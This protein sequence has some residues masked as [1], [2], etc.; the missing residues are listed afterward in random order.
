V[1]FLFDVKHGLRCNA[2]LVARGHTTAEPKDNTYSNVASPFSMIVGMLLAELNTL[3]MC[4]G[5]VG[6]TYLEAYAEDKAV[7]IVGTEFGPLGGHLM[8]IAKAMHG[9]LSSG[10]SS[11]HDKFAD[12]IHALGWFPS[13]ADSDVWTKDCGML[14]EYLA[15]YVDALLYS[16][17][18]D[19]ALFGELKKIGYKLNGVGSQTYHLG[20]DFEHVTDPGEVLQWGSHTFINN[21][22]GQDAI[23]FGE[24][25]HKH[26]IHAPLDPV[27]HHELDTIAV[28]G[29]QDTYL[30][31][32]M[33]GVIQWDV[34]L[35]HM[36]L[37]S[38]MTIMSGFRAA[39]REC[40]L[41]RLTRVYAYLCNCRR[42]SIKFRT[43]IPDYSQFNIEQSDWGYDVYHPCVED[44]PVDTRAITDVQTSVPHP[45]L[46]GT[47]L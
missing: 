8:L 33:I 13:N 1:H 29:A 31:L 23:M 47:P 14:Y 41:V 17:K 4:A 36:D 44:E 21:M 15:T 34:I 40:H 3:D 39:S 20:G 35:G 46:N 19:Q 22:I 30:Y 38:A 25:V 43:D 11:Y 45:T 9:L 32:S 12:I 2:H 7:F 24:P 28:L 42:T 37:F 6:N 26:D 5:D 16:G 27:D 18:H 10:A